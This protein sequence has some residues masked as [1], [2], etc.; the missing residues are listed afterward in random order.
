MVHART[1]RLDSQAAPAGLAPA[2]H[3]LCGDAKAHVDSV[4]APWAAA[5]CGTVRA[6]RGSGSAP[7]HNPL[8]SEDGKVGLVTVAWQYNENAVQN[9]VH[10]HD[11]VTKVHNDRVQYEFTGNGFANLAAQQKG[12]PP[13]VFGFLAALIILGIVFRTIPAALTPLLSAAAALG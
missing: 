5:S 13:E 12:I 8:R 6:A 11:Q 9:F 7:A 2:L 4:A 10:V 3:A 1:G